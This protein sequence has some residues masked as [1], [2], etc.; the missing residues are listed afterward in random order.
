MKESRP[1]CL[2]VAK[3]GYSIHLLVWYELHDRMESAITREK[4]LKEWKRRWKLNLI[5]ADNPEWN[6]LYPRIT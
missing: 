4:R 2:S 6:D 5:E 1:F 3:T